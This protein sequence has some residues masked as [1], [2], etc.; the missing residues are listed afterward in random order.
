MP[1]TK[2]S[3]CRHRD[4]NF[5]QVVSP[6]ESLTLHAYGLAAAIGAD[7]PKHKRDCVHHSK[8]S[9]I[10]TA[11]STSEYMRRSVC[12]LY[13][14]PGRR[15]RRLV[16]T[17]QTSGTSFVARESTRAWASSN[18]IECN[19]RTSSARHQSATRRHVMA[20]DHVPRRDEPACGRRCR[21]V[22]RDPGR[23]WRSSTLVDATVPLSAG[24]RA[25]CRFAA[26]T[27]PPR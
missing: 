3:E 6:K 15:T 7:E 27:V 14:S 21:G 26:V 9:S 10:R 12:A 5:G 20:L 17:F 11:S 16:P 13:S 18:E 24:R 22:R 2:Y 1:D 25:G 4:R 23:V 8:R 19:T